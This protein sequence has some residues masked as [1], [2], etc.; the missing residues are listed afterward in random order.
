MK[1]SGNVSDGHVLQKPACSQGVRS[2]AS[3]M[4]QG[5]FEGDGRRNSPKRV[6]FASS[7]KF[8][9]RL[10]GSPSFLDMQ[11]NAKIASEA[12]SLSEIFVLVLLLALALLAPAGQEIAHVNDIILLYVGYT[13]V[14][15]LCRSPCL[16]INDSMTRSSAQ[17]LLHPARRRIPMA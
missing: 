15:F 9:E 13:S 7:V 17:R 16:P 2:Q 10:P 11:E 5:G 4:M 3:Q 1:A 6:T 8:T 14:S 12:N